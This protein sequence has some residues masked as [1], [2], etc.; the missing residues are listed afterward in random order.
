M[1]LRNLLVSAMVLGAGLSSG[2]ILSAKAD[3]MVYELRTYTASPG[4]MPELQKRFR[5]HTIRIFEKHGIKS[6]GYWVPEKQ[7]DTLVYLVV[8]PSRKAADKAWAAFIADP[9]WQKVFRESQKNGSLT[10]NV[11]RV[12]LNPTDFSPLK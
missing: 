8:H 1:T 6:I 7:P 3:D 2:E 11:E 10:K 12:Y 4:K 9:E 5:D